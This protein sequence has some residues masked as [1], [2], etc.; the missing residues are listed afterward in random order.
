RAGMTTV[1]ISTSDYRS[2]RGV[3]IAADV[4][5]WLRLRTRDGR[6]RWGVPSQSVPGLYHVVDPAGD[7]CDCEDSRRHPELVCK[8]RTAVRLLAA[9]SGGQLSMLVQHNPHPQRLDRKR[10]FE[11]A[12]Q[13]NVAHWSRRI[14]KP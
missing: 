13:A 5:R 4:K 6:P 2:V 7:G 10:R 3:E 12:H 11:L 9:V 14:E 1:T 8:H